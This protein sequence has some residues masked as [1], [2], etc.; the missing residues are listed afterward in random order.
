[1][2]SN[3][4]MQKSKEKTSKSLR[5]FYATMTWL[6]VSVPFGRSHNPVLSSFVTYHWICNKNNKTGATCGAGTVSLS[7]PAVLVGLMLL[8]L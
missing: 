1:M 2:F 7:S 3:M 6:P 5:K 8:D 4:K